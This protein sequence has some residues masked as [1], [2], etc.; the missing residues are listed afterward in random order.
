MEERVVLTAELRDEASAPLR[1]INRTV[2]GATKSI[3]KSHRRQAAAATGAA[4]ATVSAAG[5]SNNAMDRMQRVFSRGAVTV[6]KAYTNLQS[7]VAGSNNRIVRS[8]SSAGSAVTGL[9]GRAKQGGRDFVSG[10]RSSQ[11]AASSFTGT[12]GSLGGALGSATRGAASIGSSI[13]SALDGAGAAAGRLG[14]RIGSSVSQG[15]RTAVSAVGT[16]TAAVGAMALGGGLNRMLKIEDAQ[17]KLTGLG[18]SAQDVTEIMKNASASVTGTAF[19]LDAAAT[20]AASAMAAGI[21]PG[22]AMTDYLTLV[23]DAATIAGTDMAEMGQIMGKVTNTGKMTTEV[24][25]QFGDRGVGVLNMLADAYGV[26]VAAMQ[27]MVTEGEISAA[28]F[29]RVL[30]DR[31]GGAAQASGNTTR[32][33]FANMRAAMSRTGEALLTGFFPVFKVVFGTVQ[34]IFNT[35][36]AS[37][38]EGAG[39]VGAAFTATATPA[40]Q[41]FG[42]TASAWLGKAMEGAG[43]LWSLLV[44]RDFTGAFR[45]VFGVEEDAPVV[46]TLFRIRDGLA[47]LA[48]LAAPIAA[49]M[50]AVGTN[51]MKS[52]PVIGRF[53]P[54]FN[55]VLAVVA[56]LIA[57]SPELREALMSAFTTLAPVVMEAGAVLSGL[58]PILATVV[59]EAVKFAAVVIDR[60]APALPVLIPAVLAAVAAFKAW[61]AITATLTG[62]KLGFTA[63]TAGATLATKAQTGATKAGAAAFHLKAAALKVATGA[64][65]LF[66]LA[67]RANPIGIIITAIAALVAGLVWFFTQTETGKAIVAAA[68]EWMQGAMSAVVDWWNG[69]LIP[70]LQSVGQWFADVWQGAKD[71][72]GAAVDWMTEKLGQIGS[73]FSSTFGPVLQWLGDLFA[74]VWGWISLQAENASLIIRAVAKLAVDFWQAHVA[75]VLQWLGQ[76]FATIWGGITAAVQWA[77]GIVQTVIGALVEFWNAY[78]L[79]A[80]QWVGDLFATIWGGVLT[81]VSWVILGVQTYIGL[82]VGFWTGVLLPALQWVG[83][84]FAT[85]WGGIRTV[86][87]WVVSVVQSAVQ[88]LIDFWNNTLFPAIAAVAGWFSDK[89]ASAIDG[90]TGFIGNVKDGFQ[91]FIDFISSKVQPIIDAIAGSFSA[92]GDK[93]GSVMGH[94]RDFAANPLGGLADWASGVLDNSGGGV[95]SGGGVAGFAGGGVLGGYAPGKDTIPAMLSKGEA[96]LVPEL[97]RAIGARNIMALNHAYSGGRPAGGGPSRAASVPDLSALMSSVGGSSERV[98]AAGGTVLS[99]R[100]STPGQRATTEGGGTATLVRVEE[101]AVQIG[102]TV[103]EGGTVTETDLE[104]IKEAVEEVFEEVKRRGY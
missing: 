30:R 64:Q 19:G 16:I 65:K 6:G 5:T 17:A 20:V 58:L 101:G 72:V 75:P 102:I 57:T 77:V 34:S 15:A 62:L 91:K 97:V 38:K 28:D 85:I 25:Y 104:A 48:P 53:I 8:V 29:E 45:G 95:Y 99:G 1:Q 81:V 50:L 52:L 42:E 56:T 41:S 70:A 33:A 103:A 54:A 47:G 78:L 24:L 11:A 74:S 63:A 96:V 7:T 2:D 22:Q 61:R 27:D 92:L 10:F 89:L 87:Q 13:S 82:L 71:A 9:F 55:P 49:G 43:A 31:V 80:L 18:V 26:P 59:T 86:V 21:K 14:S 35:F 39:A 66:N 94:L 51:L 36:T 40:L 73:W 44:G 100:S 84:L 46:D 3:E 60:L 67:L 79:P 4:R 83:N 98:H 32:G 93:V 12:L 88:G 37:I 69:T 90:V 76:L 68:W 23:A